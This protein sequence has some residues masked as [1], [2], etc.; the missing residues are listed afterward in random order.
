MK[1]LFNK[2]ESK[3]FTRLVSESDTA[4]FD[5]G[6]VHHVLSTFALGRDAEWVCRLFVI[7]MIEEQ[8]EGIGTSLNIKHISPAFV[9]ETITYLAKFVHH[10]GNTVMCSFCAKVGTRVVANGYTEQKIVNK[11]KIN[12]LFKHYSGEGI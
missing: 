11:E 9:G 12:Q 1:T 6:E 5:S 10:Q 7:D 2:G 8:E 4:S 3:A